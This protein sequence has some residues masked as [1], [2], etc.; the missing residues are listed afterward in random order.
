MLEYL[1]KFGPTNTFKLAKDLDADRYEL[2]NAIEKLKEEGSIE[3]KYG[4]ASFV[5]F[6]KT[7]FSLVG[8]AR[9]GLPKEDIKKETEKRHPEPKKKILEK[10]ETIVK[11]HLN[12]K[13]QINK[14]T[15]RIDDLEKIVRIIRKKSYK[16]AETPA[17]ENEKD[18]TN[19]KKPKIGW[20]KDIMKKLR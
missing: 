16:P 8:Q 17:E 13:N 10:L 3:F 12:L 1:K 15:R 14:Q 11:S 7:P 6:P 20:L 19:R 4:T 18:K 9:K 2:L 5:R